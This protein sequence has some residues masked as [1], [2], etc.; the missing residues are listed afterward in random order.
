MILIIANATPSQ[1]LG[2]SFSLNMT[3]PNMVEN[4]TMAT[5]FIVNT[6]EL[7]KPFP[8][9]ACMRKYIEK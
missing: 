4:I 1:F 7:S 2:I 9:K 3:I 5:L 8:L 6:V